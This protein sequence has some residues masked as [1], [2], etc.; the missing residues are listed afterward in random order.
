VQKQLAL[1]MALFS[2]SDPRGG[3]LEFLHRSPECR[4]KA[5]KR[6]TRG[7]G[8]NWATLSLRDINTETWPSTL[9]VG[10][11]IT[12]L[13]KK[14]NIFVTYKKVKTGWSNLL[15]MATDQKGLFCR[16]WWSSSLYYLS[17]CI[18]IKHV[19]IGLLSITVKRTT[20]IP[21]C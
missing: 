1:S 14:K 12:L 16:W 20:P 3:G 2:R 4:R 13:C 8:Y 19:G 6:G 11:K 21:K 17:C 10:S 18:R 15:R 7:W 9:G 5:T